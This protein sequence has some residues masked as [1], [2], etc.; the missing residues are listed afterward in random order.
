MHSFQ[1]RCFHVLLLLFVILNKFGRS[2]RGEKIA[3]YCTVSESYFN[4]KRRL[5]RMGRGTFL[6]HDGSSWAS[7]MSEDHSVMRDRK[8][9][10]FIQQL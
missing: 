1:F 6:E 4:Y 10:S 7:V 5:G 3:A 2:K 9:L 8:R